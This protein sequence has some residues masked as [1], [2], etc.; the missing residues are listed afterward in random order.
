MP[1]SPDHKSST[2][3]QKV[4]KYIRALKNAPAKETMLYG[5]VKPADDHSGIFFAPPGD[6]T[7]WAFIPKGAIE[8]I[9]SAGRSRCGGHFHELAE[10]HLKPPA[11]ELE[12]AYASI[13]DLH[14]TKL[15]QISER[16]LPPKPNYK[17]PKGEQWTY[18]NFSGGWFCQ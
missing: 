12:N 18:D 17:C 6:C 1:K 3:E 11:S 14:R 10:I 7:H 15:A 5:M 9:Q 8:D 13:A 4:E 16:T 2:S